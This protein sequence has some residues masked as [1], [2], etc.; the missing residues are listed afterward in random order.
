MKIK[1]IVGYT[2]DFHKLPL[3]H[4][5]GE[6]KNVVFGVLLFPSWSLYDLFKRMFQLLLLPAKQLLKDLE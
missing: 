5:R 6:N 3:G 2:A 4:Q 1:L